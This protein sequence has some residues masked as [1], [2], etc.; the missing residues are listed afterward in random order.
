ML[1]PSKTVKMVACL[2]LALA[3]PAT[4]ARGAADDENMKGDEKMTS[5]APVSRATSRPFR[6]GERQGP[7]GVLERL[8][9]NAD[10]LGLTDDQKEQ[11]KKLAEAGREKARAIFRDADGDREKVRQQL[12]AMAR[13]TMEQVRD[14][15]TPEQ[16]RKMR[17]LLSEQSGPRNAPAGNDRM[18]RMA[19]GDGDEMMA[20]KAPKSGKAKAPAKPAARVASTK[21]VDVSELQLKKLDGKPLL[22]SAMTGKPVVL[23]FGSYTCPSFRENA[24]AF[25]DL[26]RRYATKASFVIVYTKEAHPAGGWE[27]Q[28]NKDAEIS[29]PPHADEPARLAAARQARTSL[30]L[31]IPKAVDSMDDQASTAF[32]AFPNGCVVLD[33]AGQEVA[34]Q[35]WASPRTLKITLDELLATKPATRAAAD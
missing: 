8:R 33:R 24:R 9:D 16:Q 11:I 28:R 10:K 26:A 12:A 15:L 31:A 5:D 27:V 7:G 1:Q 17:D 13:D 22:F 25:E 6:P 20:G 21:P 32:N 18:K 3:G 23:I 4:T 34:R 19:E 30:G 35:Q 2:A 14:V 29:L